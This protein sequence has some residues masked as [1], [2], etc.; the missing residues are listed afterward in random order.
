MIKKYRK[1]TKGRDFVVGDIH[2]C[3]T[4]LKV[5]LLEVYF[6]ES[7][8]R[9]F[10]VGDLVDRGNESEQCLEWINKPW[11]HAVRGNHEQMA[12]DYMNGF[13][14]V[15]CY[16]SNGG[17]WFLALE[18]DEQL[19]YSEAFNALPIAIEVGGGKTKVGIV[20][21]ECPVDDWKDLA[22]ALSNANSESFK[23]TAMWARTRI[24]YG[25]DTEI[26]NISCVFVGHTPLQT[27]MRLGNVF[28]I[29]TGAV[30][31]RELTMAQIQP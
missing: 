19:K 3:F 15:G 26:K 2:G 12:I 7:K 29:D 11:F 20:H 5:K 25:I 28:Y 21:A 9:L 22:A 18:K 8:D 10:S 23:Q 30:F 27:P 31:G 17:A 13:A 1:N 6:N 4:Q 14:D 24:T 16:I